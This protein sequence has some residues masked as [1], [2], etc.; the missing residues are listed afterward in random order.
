MKLNW[1]LLNMACYSIEIKKPAQKALL[2]LPAPIVKQISKLIDSLRD[3]PL[4]NGCKKLSG[5]DNAYRVRVG[6]YRIV[7]TIIKNRL[8][9]EIIKIGHRKDVYR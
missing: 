4:P 6:D 2:S 8:I 5:T 3:N 1:N 9:I 7:Y